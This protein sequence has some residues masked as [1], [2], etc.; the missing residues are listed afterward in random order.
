MRL[1]ALDLTAPCCSETS[2]DFLG[3]TASEYGVLEEVLV[4]SPQHLSI[5]PCNSVSKE[6]LWRGQLSCTV[7][8]KGQ[9]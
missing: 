8:A 1:M 7:S 9:H 4:A 3:G 2:D 5:V 6:A